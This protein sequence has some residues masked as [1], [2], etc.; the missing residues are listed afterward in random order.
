MRCFQNSCTFLG[1]CNALLKVHN[2]SVRARANNKSGG[3]KRI[4]RVTH[5]KH[6]IVWFQSRITMMIIK[7]KKTEKEE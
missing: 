6:F 2:K 3:E 5:V 1:K 4:Y 7:E